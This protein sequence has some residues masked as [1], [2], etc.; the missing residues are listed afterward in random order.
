MNTSE[1][2]YRYTGDFI[3]SNLSGSVFCYLMDKRN[4]TKVSRDN[5]QIDDEIITNER[6]VTVYNG[7]TGK[8]YPFE[9]NED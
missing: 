9:D 4:L 8:E 3:I 7:S 6:V 2:K 5:I 1:K